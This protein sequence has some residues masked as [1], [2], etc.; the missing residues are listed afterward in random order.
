MAIHFIK[1]FF[2]DFTI[3]TS[4]LDCDFFIFY[5]SLNLILCDQNILGRNKG[6]MEPKI[7]NERENFF[8]N[9][10]KYMKKKL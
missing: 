6:I 8:D 5:L 1:F 3:W 4:S 2:N 10:K 9:V 7:T